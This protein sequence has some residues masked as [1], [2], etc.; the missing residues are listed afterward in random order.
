MIDG[1]LAVGK[2]GDLLHL[3]VEG[4][5]NESSCMTACGQARDVHATERHSAFQ[6]V[7]RRCRFNRSAP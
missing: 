4:E 5:D 3:T 7:C 1:Y 2:R 6:Q